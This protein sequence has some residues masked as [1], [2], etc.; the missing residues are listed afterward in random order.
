MCTGK[1]YWWELLAQWV[2]TIKCTWHVQFEEREK[3]HKH[4]D[5]CDNVKSIYECTSRW[6]ENF[7]F[8]TVNNIVC[9]FVSSKSTSML[10]SLL[11][12]CVAMNEF[13]NWTF[14]Y[15]THNMITVLQKIC[16]FHRVFR[17]RCCCCWHIYRTVVWDLM[18]KK[19]EHKSN[20]N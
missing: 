15:E 3:K 2:R 5:N 1:K 12:G 17:V 18:R 16:I 14:R 20:R 19:I 4:I 10:I 9:G 7:S 6:H 13:A 11:W 8:N